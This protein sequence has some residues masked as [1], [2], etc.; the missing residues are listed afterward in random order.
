MVVTD[1]HLNGTSV[2]QNVAVSGTGL[3]R[4]TS[5]ITW[6]TPSPI[7]YGTT[8]SGVLNATATDGT[9]SVDGSF[10]YT[11]TPQGGTASA[12]TAATVLEAGVYTLA[13]SFTP[14]CASYASATGS[15]SLTVS[16]LNPEPRKRRFD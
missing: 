13:V 2:T 1:N 3:S 7:T 10:A 9:S 8:L 5:T 4:I 11:A 14:S 16:D 12:V 15:V 6:A